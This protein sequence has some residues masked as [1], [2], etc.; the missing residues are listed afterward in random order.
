MRDPC[1]SRN[2]EKPRPPIH[3]EVPR[4]AVLAASGSESSG[5]AW[6]HWAEPSSMLLSL[7]HHALERL[8][9]R[10]VARGTVT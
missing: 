3:R 2:S 1:T 7:F 4:L 9:H 8:P 6:T 5:N 10:I